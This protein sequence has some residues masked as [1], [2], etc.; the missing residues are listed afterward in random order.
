MKV[1]TDADTVRQCGVLF[2]FL[3]TSNTYYL[4]LQTGTA[5]GAR[6]FNW[7]KWV[8]GAATNISADAFD[9]ADDTW[10]SIRM[11][12][13]ASTGR[14][15]ARIWETSGAEPGDWDIDATDTSLAVGGALGFRARFAADFDNLYIKGFKTYYQPIKVN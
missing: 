2:N 4:Q 6:G 15:Q 11:I 5:G 13:T 8:G 3:D 7:W 14:L 1:I 10:Y 12:F 9:A